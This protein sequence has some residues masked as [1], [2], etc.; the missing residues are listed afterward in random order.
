MLGRAWGL[1]DRPTVACVRVVVTTV[2]KKDEARRLF[3]FFFSLSVAAVRQGPFCRRSCAVRRLGPT[4]HAQRVAFSLFFAFSFL[5]FDKG[6][7]FFGD[8]QGRTNED[9]RKGI[10]KWMPQQQRRRRQREIGLQ[11]QRPR[12]KKKKVGDDQGPTRK[13]KEDGEPTGKEKREKKKEKG[14]GQEK[15]AKGR[16]NE[17][18]LQGL[19]EAAKKEKDKGGRGRCRQRS[20]ERRRDKNVGGLSLF[21]VGRR[22]AG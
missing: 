22:W 20:R 6:G 1:V 16:A 11:G 18:F 14:R 4:Q 7:R 21:F 9:F 19:D 17:D 5:F 2:K 15:G 8:L 3:F 12:R 13:K 10:S